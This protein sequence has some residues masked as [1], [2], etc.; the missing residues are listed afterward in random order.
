V[1]TAQTAT[2]SASYNGSALTATITVTAP[3]STGL[4]AAYSFSEG[5]G[6][7]VA[8]ASGNGNSGTITNATWTTSGKFGSALSFNGS[9]SWVT[10]KD[11]ASL[12]F[13]KGMTLEG[14]VNP[15]VLSGSWRTVIIKQSTGALMYALYA[16]TDTQ[17]PSGHVFI[18]SEFDT[19]G[20]GTL[21]LNAWTHLA[22]TY[23][24]NFLRLYV[25][26]ALASTKAVTGAIKTSTGVLRIGG[27]DIWGEYFSGLIDEVRIY[28]RALS[29]AEVAS[30]MNAVVKSQIQ[31]APALTAGTSVQALSLACPSTVVAGGQATC[32][33]RQPAVADGSA[34]NVAASSSVLRVPGQV[35]SRS[36]QSSL[37]FQ[38]HVDAAAAGQTVIVTAAAGSAS[39]GQTIA[40]VP[41]AAPVLTVP[42]RQSARFGKTLQFGVSAET[43]FGQ[44]VQLTAANLP[45]GASFDPASGRFEWTPA[46]S[47]QGSR[48]VSFTASANGQSS[49]TEV[50]IDVDSGAPVLDPNAPFACSPGA[51]GTLAGK[52]LSGSAH[53]ASDPSGESL[54]L[55]GTGVKVNGQFVPVLQVAAG[56]VQFLCPAL[57]AGTPLSVAVATDAAVTAPIETVMQAASPA[58]FPADGQG[59]ISFPGSDD[60][61]ATRDFRE[62][63]HPAQ[64]GDDILIWGTGFGPAG[65]D[66]ARSIRVEVGG[67]AAEVQSVNAVP[68]K[69]GVYTIRARVMPASTP[70]AAAPVRV[71][72]Y[73]PDGRQLESN[74]VTVAL[75][76]PAR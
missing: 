26:G 64:A 56:Q 67:A 36:K 20:T 30:D 59:M 73:S 3:V 34:V 47:Q 43:G 41:A 6:T 22:A 45:A 27:N 53:G 2:I 51:I 11:S 24:G 68:G 18:A 48:T 17:Q 15:T 7:T 4:V 28:N 75:E 21:A 49:T 70:D 13:T 63:G 19:R 1:T 25:N 12:D 54:S 61:A 65:T 60:L 32:E 57:P 35:Q 33:L 69:A 50:A 52:W 74:T 5:T 38:A 66:A 16:N 58:I 62:A 31:T 46:E 76:A 23:D 14:W 71:L 55:T 29:V 42:G 37:T 8:D 72:I 9:S 10:V 39:A 44:P 40:V